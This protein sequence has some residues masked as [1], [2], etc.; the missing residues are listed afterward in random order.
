MATSATKQAQEQTVSRAAIS[1]PQSH[2]PPQSLQSPQPQRPP[3]QL[4]PPIDKKAVGYGLPCARCHAY[5]PSDMAAC[6]ICKCPDRVSPTEPV[7]H[8]MVAA[9][10]PTVRNPEVDQERE[11]LLKDLK[12]Q[13]VASPAPAN[14]VTSFQCVLA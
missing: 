3:S 4:A 7:R 2:Q 9:T 6:P 10:A 11:R 8:H 12:S 13:T 1:P 14:P 5:Y